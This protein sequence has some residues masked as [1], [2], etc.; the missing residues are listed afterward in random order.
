MSVVPHTGV[1]NARSYGSPVQV[2]LDRAAPEVE[3]ATAT[4]KVTVTFDG[5]NLPAGVVPVDATVV[6]ADDPTAVESAALVE[7]AKGSRIWSVDVTVP[8]GATGVR[9]WVS[10]GDPDASAGY[11][12]GASAMTAVAPSDPTTSTS[13]S[14]GSKAT[15]SASPKATRSPAANGDH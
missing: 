12:L 1:G 9:A 4:G 2:V 3:P 8:T 5:V 6:D 13:K 11:G 14:T 7:T 10:L 15:T